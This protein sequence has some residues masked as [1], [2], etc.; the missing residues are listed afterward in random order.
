MKTNY[1]SGAVSA[2][3][4]MLSVLTSCEQRLE[5]NDPIDQI[6]SAQIFESVNTADAALSHLYTEIQAY[7]LFS[8]GSSGAGVLLGAYTDDLINNDAFNQNA[9]ADLFNNVQ[10]NSNTSIKTAWTNAYKEIYTANAIIEGIEKSTAIA[11]PDK[12]R[13]KGEA[14]FLRTLIFFYLHQLF[15]DIPYPTTTNY[16]VNQSLPKTPESEALRLIRKDLEES[17]NLLNDQYRNA[18][19]IYPNKKTA[20]LFLATVLMTQNQWSDAEI[21]LREVVPSTLYVWENDPVKTFK[22]TGKHI[23]WQLKP[24]QN[25]YATSEALLYYF[26]SGVPNTYTVAN[27]LVNSFDAADLRRQNW[28]TKITTNQ[29]AY[30]RVDKY[31]N[32]TNNTDEY[33]IVFRLE[34]AYLLL[35]EALAQ[36]NKLSAAI[37]YLNK[38]KQKAGIA[39]TPESTPKEQLLTEI[40]KENQKEFF[41]ERGIRFVTLKRAGRLNEL[42]ATKP[43]WKEHHRYWPLPISELLLNPNLNPQNNGY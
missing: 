11:E 7:S 34:E 32:I 38:V 1:I 16:T 35:A 43:N 21:L 8:G 33:S 9:G 15:G 26:S 14:L 20:Q 6:S 27:S 13:I 37:P 29:T 40:L 3:I 17:V 12:K 22:K 25:N 4:V 41:A 10:G 36:Q 23:L 24:L 30:Y 18:E 31:R 2:L 5:V 19:R 42:V 39:L 28:M